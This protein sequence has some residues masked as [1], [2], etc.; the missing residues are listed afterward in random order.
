M[1]NEII[2]FLRKINDIQSYLKNAETLERRIQ[3]PAP[4]VHIVPE[5][6]VYENNQI[7]VIDEKKDK[8]M[9]LTMCF[10]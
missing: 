3:H 9:E 4:P 1:Q 5:N 6:E 8:L 7:Q 2:V 10:V